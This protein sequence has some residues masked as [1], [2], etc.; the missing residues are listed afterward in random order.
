MIEVGHA[1]FPQFIKTKEDKKEIE[2][3]TYTEEMNKKGAEWT[4]KATP[5]QEKEATD[6]LKGMNLTVNLTGSD[7]SQFANLYAADK[8]KDPYSIVSAALKSPNTM[9]SIGTTK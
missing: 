6:K 2:I 5:Q 8:N 1:A 3:E 9:Q 4:A 7:F